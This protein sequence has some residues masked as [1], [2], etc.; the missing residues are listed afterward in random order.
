MLLLDT[1]P[2]LGNVLLLCFF[3]FFIFGIIGVQLWEGI[4][5]QRCVIQL[6]DGILKPKWVVIV[7]RAKMLVLVFSML[8]LLF[9]TFF[10]HHFFKLTWFN[11]G[12]NLFL[13]CLLPLLLTLRCQA[14]SRA[15]ERGDEHNWDV[16]FTK[17]IFNESQIAFLSTFHDIQNVC[18]MLL[19]VKCITAAQKKAQFNHKNVV[20]KRKADNLYISMRKSDGGKNGEFLPGI[21]PNDEPR[22]D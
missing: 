9:F 7:V 14:S 6:P 5:R 2:M 8:F 16:K 4:L 19:K 17:W 12:S 11:W 15:K 1:L 22:G 13:A 18:W 3:V 10:H 20:K 21:T